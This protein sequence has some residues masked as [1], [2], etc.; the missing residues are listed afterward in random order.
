MN[1]DQATLVRIRIFG[2][3]KYSGSKIC[4]LLRFCD[5]ERDEFIKQMADP[6]SQVYR[7]YHQGVAIGDYNQDV[8]LAGSCVLHP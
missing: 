4:D 1:L 8:E 5:G 3:L 7:Y 6:G 2:A